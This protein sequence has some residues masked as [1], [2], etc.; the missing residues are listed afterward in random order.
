MNKKEYFRTI[1]SLLIVLVMLFGF[2]K[3]AVPTYAVEIEDTLQDTP[4]VMNNEQKTL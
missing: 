2:S 1:K 4:F 3:T